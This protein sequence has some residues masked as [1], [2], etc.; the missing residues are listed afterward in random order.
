MFNQNF[1]LS[2]LRP[3]PYNPRRIGPDAIEQLG[4]SIQSLGPVKAVIARDDRTIV[5]GH[6]RTK[7]MLAAGLTHAPVY[8]LG[9]ISDADEVRF[10]QI[11]NSADIELGGCRISVRR[12][13]EPGWTVVEPK[14]LEVITRTSKASQLAE[15]LKLLTKFG[16]W[17]NA[18]ANTSGRILASPLYA[19]ACYNLKRPL[20][21]AVVPDD[22]SVSV[23]QFLGKQ[24]GEFHYSHLPE[25]MWAQTYAQ[26]K[27]LR[28]TGRDR[29]IE[30]R[31]YENAVIPKIS[32]TD[33]ILDFGAGQMDYVKRLRKEGFDI[34]GVE[35]YLRTP[36]SNQLD[37]SRVH[38]HIDQLCESLDAKGLY[39]VVVCDSV[40][41]SVTSVEAE[42]AV[43]TTVNAFCRPGG[44]M[45]FSGRARGIIDRLTQ[46][47]KVSTGKTRDVW[48]LDRDGITAMYQRGVWLYQKFHNLAQ[49]EELGR[50]YIGPKFDVIDHDR[51][52][53]AK[54]EIR[55]SSFAVRGYKT[56]KFTEEEY[57]AA[58]KFE[59]NL[60][61]PEG[62]RYGRGADICKAWDNAR[63]LSSAGVAGK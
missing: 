36:K 5:A 50:A 37:I 1:P 22:K 13:L 34:H 42:R 6:Q 47:R 38:R 44:L 4:R 52:G 15:I 14:D 31:C 56:V 25:Q 10:N 39:D 17:G 59:F 60:P 40:I 58:L 35:F 19:L 61:L 21:L 53:N 33:R 24:Y 62:K 30:S 9:D 48:F 57:H 51:P 55:A 54:T 29:T 3:A 32:K 46:K 49:V 12:K 28:D 63:K 16:E 41:N 2:D 45:I 27:R 7:A 11:H 20:R 8:L 23:L 18:V 43:L 26:M